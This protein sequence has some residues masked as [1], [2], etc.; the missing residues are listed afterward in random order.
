[1]NH[2]DEPRMRSELLA[3]PVDMN[4][5]WDQVQRALLGRGEPDWVPFMEI[6][7]SRVHKRRVLGRPIH[8]LAD[9]LEVSRRLGQPSVVINVGLHTFPS[10]LDAMAA[11]HVEID[12]G[13]AAD[14]GWVNDSERRWAPGTTG[15]ISSESDLEAFPWPKQDDLDFGVFDEARRL[16][17]DNFR[18][19]VA[20]GKV[21]N[22]G[23]WLTGF[24]TYAYALI[25]QPNLVERM[26]AKIAEIQGW[27]IERALTYKCTGMIWHADDVAYRTGLMVSP[28]VLRQHIFPVYKRFNQICRERDVLSVFHSDGDVGT[29]MGDIVDAGFDAFN[30]IEPVAMDIRALKKRVR[31]KL[32]L[33]G[34]VDLS[35]T[36]TRGTPSEVEAEVRDLIRDVA[37]GGGYALASANSIPEYVPWENF[38]AMHSAWLKYGQYPISSAQSG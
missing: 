38:V 25:D 35:Y 22:L 9:E 17:P 5:D 16:L 11:T 29:V 32:G 18:V 12:D 26:H 20:L 19:I 27:V 28:T 8:T 34:N 2:S 33:I 7:L 14:T 31:G 23:W 3:L 10:V 30:P 21:F 37:P 15:V 1:M 13:F 24:D 36:L 4:P 6:G